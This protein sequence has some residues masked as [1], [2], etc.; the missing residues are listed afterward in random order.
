[1][2]SFKIMRTLKE[3]DDGAFR[4]LAKLKE[5]YLMDTGTLCSPQIITLLSIIMQY[6]RIF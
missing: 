5:E 1:M 2:R 4:Y 3:K 6:C